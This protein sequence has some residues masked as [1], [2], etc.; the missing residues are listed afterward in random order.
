MIIPSVIS[1]MGIGPMPDYDAEGQN[2]TP[3]ECKD[4]NDN[5]F[6]CL[7]ILLQSGLNLESR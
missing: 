4:N 6:S 7:N 2:V 5:S 1:G 3:K